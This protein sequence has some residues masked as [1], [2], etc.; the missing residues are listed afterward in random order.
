MVQDHRASLTPEPLLITMRRQNSQWRIVNGR[1]E[2]LCGTNKTS[3]IA[4]ISGLC[5]WIEGCAIH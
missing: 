1:W 5:E 4:Q 2:N 3:C